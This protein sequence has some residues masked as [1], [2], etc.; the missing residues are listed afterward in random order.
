MSNSDT[1]TGLWTAKDAERATNGAAEGDW[2]ASGVSIDTRA[3]EPGDLFTAIRGPN[4][5]GH[6]HVADALAKGAAAAM[7]ERQFKGVASSGDLPQSRRY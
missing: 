1:S 6:D 3:I 7:V 5:D 4:H 2:I